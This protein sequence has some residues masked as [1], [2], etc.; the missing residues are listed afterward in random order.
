MN[1]KLKHLLEKYT[2]LE[3]AVQELV[4]AQCTTLCAQCTC[5]CCRADIC[6]EAVD[7]PFL[8]LVHK[9]TAIFSDRYGFL[10]E[11]GCGLETGRPPVCY[12][13]FCTDQLY[14][15]YDEIRE[16]ILRT[17]GAL[18]AH[19]GR[20]AT[21]DTHLVEIM[22][23]EQLEHLAFQ[24]LEKNMKECFQALEIIKNFYNEETLPSHADRVLDR[25]TFSEEDY[26]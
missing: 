13:Y 22:K 26:P 17:L 1:P 15:Q 4:N 12:E 16:K 14:H 20:N 2:E 25:I 24:R 8:K 5:I 18:P 21:G 3:L 11:T 19:A 10:I 23:E 6:E 7:S 9:Q